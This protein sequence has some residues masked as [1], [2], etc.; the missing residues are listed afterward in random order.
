[1]PSTRTY[2]FAITVTVQPDQVLDVVVAD[3]AGEGFDP[4]Q[5]QT[6]HR[7]YSRIA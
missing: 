6:A 2:R 4:G 1:M 5:I 3:R 7:E